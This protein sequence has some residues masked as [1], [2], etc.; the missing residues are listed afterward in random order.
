MILAVFVPFRLMLSAASTVLRL[1]LWTMLFWLTLFFLTLW[2]V[3]RS[4]WCEHWDRWFLSLCVRSHCSWRWECNWVGWFL[5]GGNLVVGWSSWISWDWFWTGWSVLQARRWFA[6]SMRL[7][8]SVYWVLFLS[9]ISYIINRSTSFGRIH[10]PSRFL[11][12]KVRTEISTLRFIDWAG[13]EDSYG[14]QTS[15]LCS[16]TCPRSLRWN[17]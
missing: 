10:L 11:G 16:A 4:A 12:L 3:L 6:I 7:L 8:V 17:F 14:H 15:I 9:Q 2:S 5:P 1:W 13:F